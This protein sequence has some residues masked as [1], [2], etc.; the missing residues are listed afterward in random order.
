MF[1]KI[2]TGKVLSWKRMNALNE[3]R[4]WDVIDLPKGKKGVECKRIFTKKVGA[5]GN[6][7]RYEARLVAQG[8]YSNPWY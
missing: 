6:I 1:F 2:Q 8:V 3:N 7:D 5:N 4:T